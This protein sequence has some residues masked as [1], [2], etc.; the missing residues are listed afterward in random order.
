[1][2]FLI[3]MANLTMIL[4]GP[5]FIQYKNRYGWYHAS[6]EKLYALHGAFMTPK[7]SPIN[8]SVHWIHKTV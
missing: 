5:K 6:K 2:I 1:M 7:A 4:I 8:A 3:R